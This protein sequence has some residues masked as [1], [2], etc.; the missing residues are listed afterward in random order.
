MPRRAPSPVA[1]RMVRRER[2]IAFS[3]IVHAQSLLQRAGGK[4][5][6]YAARVSP[7]RKATH[8]DESEDGAAADGNRCCILVHCHAFSGGRLFRRSPASAAKEQRRPSRAI[9]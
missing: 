5:V 4:A 7:P 6:W 8:E 3:I 2:C 9:A 1:F